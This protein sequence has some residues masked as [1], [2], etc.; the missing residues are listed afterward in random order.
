MDTPSVT[1][2]QPKPLTL[3]RPLIWLALPLIMLIPYHWL[4]YDFLSQRSVRPGL[5][6]EHMRFHW[7]VFWY[8]TFFPFAFVCFLT[9]TI[10]LLR[11]MRYSTGARVALVPAALFTLLTLGILV[12]FFLGL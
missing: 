10:M 6:L 3:R 1:P 12:I 9:S 2:T 11:R 8:L 7:G 4:C 5:D